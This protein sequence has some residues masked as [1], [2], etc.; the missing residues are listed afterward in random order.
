[1]NAIETDTECSVLKI[2][3]VYAYSSSLDSKEQTFNEALEG[4][5]NSYRCKMGS[6]NM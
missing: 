2:T 1:M 4:N 5:L 6:V 3:R